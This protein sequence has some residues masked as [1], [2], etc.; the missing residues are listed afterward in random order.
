MH[1]D[2]ED[3]RAQIYDLNKK[4]ELAKKDHTIN[5]N[6]FVNQSNDFFEN[7]NYKILK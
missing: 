2:D 3:L 7:I 1:G 4:L 6:Q 5:L